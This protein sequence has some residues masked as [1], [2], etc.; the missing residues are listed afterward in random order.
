MWCPRRGYGRPG[1]DDS[2]G[3]GVAGTAGG[4]FPPR[5]KGAAMDFPTLR[6]VA[7]LALGALLPVAAFWAGRGEA[8]VVLAAA[9]VALIAASVFRLLGPAGG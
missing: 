5:A 4:F 1:V 6:W 9:C 3:S 2:G 7:L 8:V